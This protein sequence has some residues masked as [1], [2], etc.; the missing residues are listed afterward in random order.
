MTF[1][2]Q[3]LLQLLDR[4]YKWLLK[5]HIVNPL[6]SCSHNKLPG[7]CDKPG[8]VLVLWTEGKKKRQVETSVETRHQGFPIEVE[9]S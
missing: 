6:Q 4:R 8:T 7:R 9:S 5:W 1:L 3:N 2:L